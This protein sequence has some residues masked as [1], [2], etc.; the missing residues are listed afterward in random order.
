MKV[1]DDPPIGVQFNGE[2]IKEKM[3]NE[4]WKTINEP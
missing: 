2:V 3:I 4:H 1:Y